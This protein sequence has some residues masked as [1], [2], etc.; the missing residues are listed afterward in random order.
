[1]SLFGDLSK[2]LF[3]GSVVFFLCP[4]FFRRNV[5]RLGLFVCSCEISL[6]EF[7]YVFYDQSKK[8]SFECQVKS[9]LIA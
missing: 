1:M 2:P 9:F 5:A 3:F 4:L 8:M 7:V 6:L